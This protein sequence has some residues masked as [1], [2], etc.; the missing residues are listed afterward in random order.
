MLIKPYIKMTVNILNYL[1]FRVSTFFGIKRLPVYFNGQWVRLSLESWPGFYK[2]YE[3]YMAEAIKEH[4]TTGNVF[5]DVGAHFGLWS[6]FATTLVGDRGTVI[7]CEPSEAF[8]VL[9]KNLPNGSRKA[10][11]IGVGASDTM[12][13]FF[14]QGKAMSGSFYSRVT[15]LNIKYHPDIPII[16]NTVPIRS[17]DSLMSELK[18]HPDVIKVDVEGFEY[19]VLQGAFQLLRSESPIMIIEV[20][21]PQLKLSGD[22]EEQLLALLAESGYSVKIIDRNPN[23]LYTILAKGK[24]KIGLTA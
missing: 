19:K 6:V 24:S 15:E 21:P 18:L 14:G 4:L 5:I 3:P 11:R 10:L 23:S 2:V 13:S 7:A 8:E 22:S 12:G 1:A 17:L 9:V 20:H 16:E